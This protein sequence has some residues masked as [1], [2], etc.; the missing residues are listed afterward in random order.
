M[1][2]R[3]AL[4]V[5]LTAG[6]FVFG[7]EDGFAQPPA[8]EVPSVELNQTLSC[9]TRQNGPVGSFNTWVR[10]LVSNVRSR[11]T[12]QTVWVRA[13]YYL[14]TPY[15]FRTLVYSTNWWEGTATSWVTPITWYERVA[16]LNGFAYTGKRNTPSPGLARWPRETLAGVRINE[17][18]TFA[19]RKGY[20][21]TVD[22]EFYWY[23]TNGWVKQ[24]VTAKGSCTVR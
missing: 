23:T 11:Y 21:F 12:Q 9:D 3:S 4:T 24:L 7:S 20:M 6:L 18:V 14:Q 10:P 2:S 8:G 19:S 13:N 17:G 22:V 16:T 5:F 15:V 1:K